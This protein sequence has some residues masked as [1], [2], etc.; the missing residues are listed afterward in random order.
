MAVIPIGKFAGLNPSIPVEGSLETGGFFCSTMAL[1]S[2]ASN[3]SY[4]NKA[5]KSK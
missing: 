4:F 2:S 1:I 5:S 3:V